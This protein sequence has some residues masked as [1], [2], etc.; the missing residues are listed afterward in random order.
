MHGSEGN[1]LPEK[2]Q[3]VRRP[4]AV[5][6]EVER[7]QG[8]EGEENGMRSEVTQEGPPRSAKEFGVHLQT[9]ERRPDGS[10]DGGTTFLF[11][12][13]SKY[14]GQETGAE[15]GKKKGGMVCKNDPIPAH[16]KCI[17]G[18]VEKHRTFPGDVWEPVQC[19]M[20]HCVS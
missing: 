6:E 16:L 9:V 11:H 12:S 4:G 7:E 14:G 8:K 17:C 3:C 18:K 15:E 2:E 20:F 13:G 1:A 19:E 5:Y 10:K